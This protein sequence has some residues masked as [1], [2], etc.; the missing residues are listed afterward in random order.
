MRYLIL[1]AMGLCFFHS[2]AQDQIKDSKGEWLVTN[3]FGIATLEADNF[4]K[5]NASVFEGL[6]GREFFLNKRSSI[7]TG[8]EFLRVRGDFTDAFG[9]QLFINNNHINLPVSYRFYSSEKAPLVMYGDIGAYGAYLYKSE[10]ENALTNSDNE[11]TGLGLN[12]GL[13]V[14]LG[15][16]Y[17]LD[18]DYSFTLGF[19]YKSDFASSYDDSEQQ[20]ELTDFY[21]IQLG[22]G[23][24]L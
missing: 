24:N 9:S 8:L 17:K 5:V 16:K 20:F 18:D 4:F 7:I 13:Q 11:E 14:N 21:A 22:L 15:L 12:F 19:R 3:Q 10:I 6:L 1:L 2:Q 23:F